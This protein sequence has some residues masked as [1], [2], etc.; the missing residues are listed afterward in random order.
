MRALSILALEIYRKLGKQYPNLNE[1]REATKQ[2]ILKEITQWTVKKA[3]HGDNYYF[4]PAEFKGAEDSLPFEIR[5][6]YDVETD[7]YEVKFGNLNG[8]IDQE[9]FKWND[10]DPYKLQ[11]SLFLH[12]VFEKEIVP[13]MKT[14]QIGGLQF[15]PY[16]KDDLGD[17]RLSYFRNMFDKLGKDN[18]TWQYDDEYDKYFIITKKKK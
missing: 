5:L 13:L 12:T 6:I 18:F 16:S 15:T 10:K 1:K 3:E 7:C 2:Y 14:G 17:D 9:K 4:K 11:K 8:S